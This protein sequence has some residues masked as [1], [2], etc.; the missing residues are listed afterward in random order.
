MMSLSPCDG[1]G[2]YEMSGGTLSIQH[3]K[4]GGAGTSLWDGR[5]YGTFLQSGGAITAGT[6][7]VYVNSHASSTLELSG[8]SMTVGSLSVSGTMKISQAAARIT[9]TSDGA[10]TS[11]SIFT[12]VAGSA[13]H[14]QGSSFSVQGTS[15]TAMAGLANL[16]LIV[17]GG[18][19][20]VLAF[21]VA[22][23]DLGAV[24]D[25]WTNN[26]VLGT[27]TLGGTASGSIKLTNWYSNNAGWSGKEALYVENLVL[28]AGAVV[29]L[30]GLNLYYRNG[31]DP[32]KLLFGDANLD[33][34]I[35]QDDYKVWY[36]NYGVGGAWAQGNFK[37]A[38]RTDQDDYK[39]WY[40]NYGAGSA[41]GDVPEP[42]T[43][44]LLALGGIGLLAR[45]RATR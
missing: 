28:N 3:G 39:T 8:G 32:K 41:G 31:G 29:D 45:R 23:R 33:G 35:D 13:L 4:I 12:A 44:A 42:A 20:N 26:F 27:L 40:D 15:E 11:S 7:D 9:V 17:E 5:G 22:G 24:A 10:F 2:T 19:A 16:N 25:G 1:F 37:G 14:M 30:G 43:M 34:L 36:D 38:G 6:L 18:A 21:E